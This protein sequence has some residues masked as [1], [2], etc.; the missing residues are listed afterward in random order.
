MSMINGNVIKCH[1]FHQLKERGEDSIDT[2]SRE[3]EGLS[4]LE[5]RDF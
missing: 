5:I 4:R 1:Q 3:V 2:T